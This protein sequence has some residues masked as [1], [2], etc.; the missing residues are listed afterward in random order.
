M[1]CLKLLIMDEITTGFDPEVRQ[2]MW[3]SFDVIRKTS[4]ITI[5]AFHSRYTYVTG[6]QKLVCGIVADPTQHGAHLLY[7]DNIWVLMAYFVVFL[8]F[9]S[10]LP[11]KLSET[12]FEMDAERNALW[13]LELLPVK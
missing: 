10:G 8:Q 11:C 5:V 2:K 12:Q 4:I 13:Y 3:Q 6:S 9:H 7:I 1:G